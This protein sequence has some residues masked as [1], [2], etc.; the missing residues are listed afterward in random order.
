VSLVMVV[1]IV[2]VDRQA[3][4]DGVPS[5]NGDVLPIRVRYS[6]RS[7]PLLGYHRDR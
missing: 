6:V 4:G 5:Q 2:Y 7:A 3:L 1:S